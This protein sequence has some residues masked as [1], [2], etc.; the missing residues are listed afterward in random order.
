MWY[1]LLSFMYQ[2]KGGLNENLQVLNPNY[3][4]GG[5]MVVLIHNL[6]PT[7]VCIGQIGTPLLV[8]APILGN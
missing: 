4:H 1:V 2:S 6:K 5:T 8:E 3:I 7:N